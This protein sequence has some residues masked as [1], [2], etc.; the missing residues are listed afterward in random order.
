MIAYQLSIGFLIPL[1]TGQ[2]LL[3]FL[4]GRRYFPLSLSLALSYGLGTGFLTQIM[5]LL[6]ALHIPFS[7]GTIGSSMLLAIILIWLLFRSLRPA[8]KKTVDSFVVRTGNLTPS[9]L[10]FFLITFIFIN[11]VIVFWTT[12]IDPVH[13][14][15]ALAT[16]AFKAKIF[17]YER[18]LVPLEVLPH[19]SYPLYVP[20]L[21]TWLALNTGEW[22]DLWI[23]LFLPFTFLAFLIIYYEFLQCLTTRT[24]AIL[25]TALLISSH[26]F[27]YMATTPMREL[28]LIYYNCTAIMLLILWHKKQAGGFLILAGLFSGFMTFT[29]LEG[30]GYLA[31][32]FTLLALILAEQK[33]WRFR[34]KIKNGLKFFVPCVAIFLFY[35]T[36]KVFTGT[37][38]TERTIIEFSGNNFQRVPI[39][40]GEFK[41]VLLFSANWNIIWFLLLASLFLL[42][43]GIKHKEVQWL[44]ITIL[45]FLGFYFLLM[46]LVTIH[47]DFIMNMPELLPRL[48]L[49]FYPLA[50]LLIILLN[51]RGGENP[52]N[53]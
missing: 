13:A 53:S 26:Q 23:N 7:V 1:L 48:F 19:P 36:Y 44:A 8:P 32:H 29:K 46:L 31:I 9:A 37:P 39:I 4:F 3:F 34:D 24:W 45:M 30:M 25:G 40:L 33:N 18:G 20:L 2:I 14:W 38:Q 47:F 42:P 52:V 28:P 16:I 6:G 15:D 22:T 27:T 12:L 51:F 43:G 5:F 50:P 35:W 17:F 10:D 21:Q 49:H 41:E 11:V